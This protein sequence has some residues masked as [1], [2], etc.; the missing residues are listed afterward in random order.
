MRKHKTKYLPRYGVTY[1]PVTINP[2]DTDFII[3]SGTLYKHQKEYVHLMAVFDSLNKESVKAQIDCPHCKSGIEF[4][5][6]RNAVMVDEF[7]ESVFGDDI[8]LAVHPYVTGDES[9][10]ELIDFV[11]ID[12]EQ[13][14]WE[15]C[16]ES[17]KEAV[18]ESIDYQV[19][20]SI[21]EAL[22]QPALISNIPVRCSCGYET[23]VSMRGLEAF[24]KVVG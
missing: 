21:L 17:E 19:F 9:I 4:D 24:L 14:Q 16:K 10:P 5:L 22:E 18:L 12:G 15:D 3:E 23:I 20:K 8:K 2:S 13:I 6:N 11:V 1:R 7:K